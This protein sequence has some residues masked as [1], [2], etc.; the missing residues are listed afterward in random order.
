MG[1]GGVGGM[2]GMGWVRV[3]LVWLGS[4]DDDDEEEEEGGVK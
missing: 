2:D 4:D 3:A 1:W